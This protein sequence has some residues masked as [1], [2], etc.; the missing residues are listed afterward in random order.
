MMRNLQKELETWDGTYPEAWRPKPGEILVG[1]IE[2]YDEGHTSYGP[3]R[4][5]VV[6]EEETGRKLTL[7]L[8]S[9][10]LLNLFRRHK[11]R[12]GERI[13]L[14]Y[15][16]KHPEKGYHTYR[17]LVDRPVVLDE[18]TPLGGE[19]IED[20]DPEKAEHPEKD[21]SDDIPF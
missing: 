12:P 18:L 11:P 6:A 14:K 16:G 17:L 10:V 5:V 1:F 13:G 20:E 3:V 9:T 21:E 4:T 8:T 2:N 7:W 15:L 19:E